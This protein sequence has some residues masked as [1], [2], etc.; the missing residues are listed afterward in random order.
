MADIQ[1]R[2]AGVGV[3][4]VLTLSED[5]TV[6][7]AL[8]DAPGIDAGLQPRINGEAADA[9]RPLRAGD[10]VVLVPADAKLG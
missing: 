7:D 1:V 8:N 5:S 6:A 2:L 9:S 3:D 10:T 4:H